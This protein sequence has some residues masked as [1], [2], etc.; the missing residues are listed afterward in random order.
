M[1]KTDDQK[2]SRKWWWLCF[3][4]ALFLAPTSG[5]KT[6]QFGHQ[7]LHRPDIRSV[8]VEMVDNQ[9][10]RRYLGQR[11]TES[12]CKEIELNTPYRLESASMADSVLT[13]VVTRERKRSI[14]E[15]RFDDPRD[16][17]ISWQV[18][19]TWVDRSGTPL[20]QRQTLKLNQTVD[21]IPEGGQ[22]MVT[23]QQELIDR[24]A[25]QVIQQ[26]EMPW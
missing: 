26:M 11:M 10:F 16:V 4:A 25:R 14:S 22:S 19:F 5:C 7:T 1:T 12:V 15:S 21:F 24:I 2:S 13:G 6:Y 20:M 3:A 8:H 18:E 23:A 17:Q 9:T